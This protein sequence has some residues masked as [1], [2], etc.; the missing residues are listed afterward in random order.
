MKTKNAV[1]SIAI[2]ICL[3]MGSTSCAIKDMLLP[4]PS[5]TV[6]EDQQLPHKV[7]IIPFVNK[8]SN[9][10]AGSI[11]R[12]MFYN[13]FSSLNYIDLEPFV[14]DD[15]LK[16]NNLY[17]SIRT[18]ESVSATQLGQLLGVDAV[19]FGEVINLGKTYALVYADNSA[20]LK[21]KM[22]RCNSEQVIWELEHSV[23]LQEGEVPISLTG[24]ATA[25]VK[26]AIS[27]QQA[28]HLQA[29]AELCMQMIATIPNPEGLT[30]PP[31][32]I[33]VLVH[34]ASA[35]LLR[36]GDRIKVVMIGEKHQIASW[37][38]PPLIKDLPLKEKEPGIYIGAYRIRSKDRLPH[39][40]IIG[41]LRSKNGAG[42]QW[43]DTL[44]SIK[45]G[46][47]TV[48]PAVI[49]NDTILNAKKSPYL[50]EDA[51]V[52]LP[53]AKLSV[54]PGTVIWFLRLGLVVKGELQ[55]IGTEAEPVRFASLGDS[56]WKGIFLDQSHTRNKIEHA[57]ISDAEFGLR[58]ADS[59]VF[60]QNC[61]FQNNV[62]GI[63]LEE[64]TAEISKS[65][66]RTS[67][68]TGI[69]ARK[70]KLSVKDSVITENNSGGFLLEN[71]NVLIAQNNILNNGN[72]AVKVI[73]KKGKIQAAKNWWGDENPELAEIIGQLAIQ[74]VLQKPI[75]FK[76][77][78]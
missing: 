25:I 14:I 18:G 8:T 1:I 16:R 65:L 36:P 9:P 34:N 52:V 39:G 58:A 74:P 44:G 54:M 23:R 72:W 37:S 59:T 69:A 63:V 49:S 35:K 76:V 73:D 78:E 11:I 29:A 41:Y 12:K 38:I 6:L 61:I 64:G 19:I 75:K 2:V 47:P 17:Q 22:V 21:A 48:L 13:F 24:L 10:E 66:I 70:A 51:L 45:I 4:P 67:G 68:K 56:K 30:E 3:T 31:P 32:R 5:P 46:A 57:K 53:G 26:T 33:Q 40:R 7:A 62:W 60:L 43:V 27:H 15:N 77:F 28:S 55:I 71:S 50:V 42:S 20:A